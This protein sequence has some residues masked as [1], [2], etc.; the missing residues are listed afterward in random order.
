MRFDPG[1][2]LDGMGERAAARVPGQSAA[3][4]LYESIVHPGVFITPGYRGAMFAFYGDFLSAQD[5]NDL[6]AY[7][8]T[9]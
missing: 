3:D 5:V 8:L 9:L 2:N 4:Y 6:V 1:P 7:L